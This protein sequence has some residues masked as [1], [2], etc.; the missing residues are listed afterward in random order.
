[1]A[2]LRQAEPKREQFERVARHD[3]DALRDRLDE[4]ERRIAELEQRLD[5]QTP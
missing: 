5:E 1:M 4:T 2:Y 3:L